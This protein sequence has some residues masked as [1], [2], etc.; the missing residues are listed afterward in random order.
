M[1]RALAPRP[2][3]MAQ[4]TLKQRVGELWQRLSQL[5]ARPGQIAAGFTLG[6]V[7]GLVPLNPSP[8][9]LGTAAAWLLRCNV[10][11]AAV[12]G[13]L[14]LLYTPLV[15]LLWFAEYQL[16]ALVLPVP[17]PQTADPASL[18]QLVELGWQGYGAMALGTLMIATPLALV[19]YFLVRRLALRAARNRRGMPPSG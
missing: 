8:I 2:E 3:T 18:W 13:A 16:G 14:A 19:S 15:P 4:P 12:G 5:E 1:W 10:V 9:L 17:A 11:A 7:A 6:M